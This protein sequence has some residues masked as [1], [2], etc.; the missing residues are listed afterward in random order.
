LLIAD[1]PEIDGRWGPGL[2]AAYAEAAAWHEDSRL[3]EFRVSCALFEPGFRWQATYYSAE[4]QAFFATDTQE[5]SPVDLDPEEIP[6]P[7]V[8]NLSFAALREALLSYDFPD[9][10]ELRSSSGVDIR[11]NS[12]A[13]PFGPPETPLGATIAHVSI[14]FRGEVKDLFVDTATS[15]LFQFASPAG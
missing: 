13:M 7:D 3:I 10:T 14:E 15:E 1:L 2:E 11:V 4:A 8:S 5:S 6:S 9:D 12:G